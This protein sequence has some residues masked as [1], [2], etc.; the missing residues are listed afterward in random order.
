M[1]FNFKCLCTAEKIL[2]V[3]NIT[4]I[5]RPRAGSISRE[6]KTI[7]APQHFHKWISVMVVG[8]KTYKDMM[9]R[10]DFFKKYPEY[11][12]A[13]IEFFFKE[14]LHEIPLIYSKVPTVKLIELVEKE[15]QPDDATLSAYLFSTVN[16]YRLRLAKLQQENF[17]LKNELQKYQTAQ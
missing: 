4:Y 7:D 2:S 14:A 16:I 3:P 10:I 12:Y 13:V 5:I 17:A 1:I 9:N 6:K 8:T 11:C 15:F